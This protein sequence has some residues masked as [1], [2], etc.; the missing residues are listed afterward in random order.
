MTDS[1]DEARRFAALERYA[2]LDTPREAEFDDIVALAARLLD[3]PVAVVNLI[4]DGRQWFKA[5]V[6][7]GVRETPLESSFCIHALLQ[8]ELMVVPDAK[9][10]PRFSCN[11]L[12]VEPPHLRAYAG[13]LLKTPDGPP[14]GTL[15]VL[16]YRPRAFEPEQLDSLRALA[17]QVMSQ[18]ELRRALSEKRKGEAT[19]RQIL[20]SA[21]DYAII[22]TDRDG[23]ITAWNEGARRIF[24]HTEA[25]M[26]GR[27]A[28][29]IFTP[30]DVASGRPQREM[31]EALA[32]GR[33]DDERWHMRA[34]GERFWASGEMMPLRDDARAVVGFVKLVRDRTEQRL[35]SNALEESEADARRVQRQL[36]LSEE[37]LRLATDAGEIGIWDFD[38]TND[39]LN[40]PNRLRQAFGIESGAPSTIGAFFA[41]VHPDD[42]AATGA[43][44]ADA[45]DPAIRGLYDVEFRA[46]GEDGGVR[47]IAAKG[48]GV[49]DAEGRCVRAL[50]TAIDVTARKRAEERQSALLQLGD[51]LRDLGDS[52]NMAFAAAE[53][54]ATTL[55]VGR[56]GYGTI[57]PVRETITVER[58]WN[59]PGIESL[60]GVL[61]FRDYGS[62]IDDLKRGEL[63]ACEDARTD[64]RTCETAAALEAI[65]ARAFINMP[66]VEAGAFVAL[67]Y[68]NHTEP[69]AWPPEEI[70]FVRE[71]ADRTRTAVERARAEAALRDLAASLEQRVKETT[72][73]RDQVWQTSNDLLCVAD[74]KGYLLSLN[75]A[76]EATLG[77]S[78]AELK[79]RP[80][81]DF[82]HENDQAA[83]LAA[84]G[85]LAAGEPQLSFEHRCR[86]RNGKYCWLSWNA[87]PRE[88]HIYANVRDVTDAKELDQR[89]AE[90]EDQLRQAQK[91]EAV[92]QLT[93]GLAHDFNNL[94]AGISWQRWS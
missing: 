27:P 79:G 48:E 5:E 53:I 37:S 89:N 62:Y 20:D 92:G 78:E 4:A 44:F 26:C 11:P 36:D 58:D 73:E 65:S 72:R 74:F 15:C 8:D 24:G 25:A 19:S 40:W 10:D 61:Q 31:A 52:A 88:G 90:L 49:F 47:W 69:R 2:I 68:L 3:A 12:V 60:A 84:A 34:T 18:L 29:A 82:V 39:V 6:G 14:I 81:V 7:L 93:G 71:V 50:G 57:D 91:M 1:S 41:A 76:W 56:A 17:R 46:V 54:L 77:W 13:A 30:E 55:Y 22:A 38:V 9:L 23:L 83:L 87:V 59:A 28:T 70:A 86:C 67:L 35:A 33:A 42:R 80:F 32:D 85:K 75:P 94:L 63:V 51:R 66:I 45:L 16:D 43:A 21:T 64:P